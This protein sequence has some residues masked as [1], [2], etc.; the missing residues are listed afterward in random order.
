MPQ[1]KLLALAAMAW[2]GFGSLHVLINVN[3]LSFG[4]VSITSWFPT[5]CG[6]G[7]FAF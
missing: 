2:L 3:T 6:I 7:H 1:K 4:L 5:C